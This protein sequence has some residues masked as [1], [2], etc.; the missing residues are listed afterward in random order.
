MS[1]M[2][3][4]VFWMNSDSIKRPTSHSRIAHGPSS[5]GGP[6][7]HPAPYAWICTS[8]QVLHWGASL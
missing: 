8:K 6:S 1:C 5:S 7:P 4:P 3:V 2:A